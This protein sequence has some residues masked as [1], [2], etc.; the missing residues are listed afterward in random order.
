MASTA[1]LV[2]AVAIAIYVLSRPQ[3]GTPPVSEGN[4]KPPVPLAV[5]IDIQPWARVRILDATGAEVLPA[6][7][8]TPLS[9]S[10]PPGRYTLDCENGGLTARASFSLEVGSDRP[11]LV[12]LVMPGY[13]ADAAL[14]N[15]LGP[16]R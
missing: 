15:L 2:T 13:D 3:V 7:L 9:V 12:R 11:T 5:T 16:P 8:A 10:L 1:V 6:P 14:R 4:T